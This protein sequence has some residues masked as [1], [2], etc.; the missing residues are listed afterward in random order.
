MTQRANKNK[1]KT[2][3]LSDTLVPESS[4]IP[5][6]GALWA[7]RVIEK[8]VNRKARSIRFFV[9]IIIFFFSSSRPFTIGSFIR[10][11]GFLV[12][13]YTGV[14]CSHRDPE[15]TIITYSRTITTIYA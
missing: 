3:F 13:P 14:R 1:I 10:V 9:F 2:N 7:T 5:A 4:A 8:R 15:R 11:S 6:L 12:R